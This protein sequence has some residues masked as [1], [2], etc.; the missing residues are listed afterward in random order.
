MVKDNEYFKQATGLS[1][2]I[3]I[4]TD[5]KY[6]KSHFRPHAKLILPADLEK[7]YIAAKHDLVESVARFYEGCTYFGD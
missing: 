5:E 7:K 4:D 6:I 2:V 1:I 3:T